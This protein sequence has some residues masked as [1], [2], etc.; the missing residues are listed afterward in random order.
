MIRIPLHAREVAR[1]YLEQECDSYMMYCL[2][3]MNS[4]KQIVCIRVKR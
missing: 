2:R 3:L 1:K 4:L